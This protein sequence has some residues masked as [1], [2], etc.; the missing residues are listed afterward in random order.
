MRIFELSLNRAA[1]R[2][3]T[4]TNGNGEAPDDWHQGWLMGLEL[5]LQGSPMAALGGVAGRISASLPRPMLAPSLAFPQLSS[6]AAAQA[7]PT[8]T[9][10][11]AAQ[12]H[13]FPRLPLDSRAFAHARVCSATV[14]FLGSTSAQ[15]RNVAAASLGEEPPC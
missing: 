1:P 3:P 10:A 2:Q 12:D 15:S 8:A 11:A 14:G 13:P 7:S 4:H 6:A 9:L 5:L